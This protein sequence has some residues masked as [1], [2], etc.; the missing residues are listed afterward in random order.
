MYSSSLQIIEVLVNNSIAMF[1]TSP[2]MPLNEE[3]TQA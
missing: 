1:G 3:T 2:C